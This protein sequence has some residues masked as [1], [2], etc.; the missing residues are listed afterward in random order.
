MVYGKDI[1]RENVNHRKH[2][3]KNFLSKVSHTIK[4]QNF[5]IKIAVFFSIRAYFSLPGWTGWYILGYLNANF[6]PVG[7]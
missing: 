6:Q 4:I 5:A 3:H 7:S 1:S 2:K